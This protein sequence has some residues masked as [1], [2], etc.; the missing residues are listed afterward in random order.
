MLRPPLRFLSN[1]DIPGGVAWASASPRTP[2]AGGENDPKRVLWTPVRQRA[3][4]HA[5]WLVAVPYALL[6]LVG[7]FSGVAGFDAHAYWAAWSN[8]LYSAAPEQ[9][10]AYLYSPAFAEAI[11][12]LSLLSWPVFYAVWT[13]GTAATYAWLLAPLG[14]RWAL[15]LFVLTIPEIVV[16]NIWGLLAL[17]AVVGFRYPA[18]WTLPLLTKITPAVG[19]LWFAVRREWRAFAISLVLALGLALASVAFA[20]HLWVQWVRL[21]V[22]PDQYANPGRDAAT[23]LVHVPLFVRLPIAGCLT[24]FAARTNRRLVLPFAM[25]LA[26]PVFAVSTFQILAALPRMA[27][28]QRAEGKG[29]EAGPLVGRELEFSVS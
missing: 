14:R 4:R 10:D 28:Q 1:R 19:P 21:L 5:I 8:G 16:G 3:L 9:R 12:P 7:A 18:A 29:T 25:V 15:P 22:H 11:W 20:P 27:E 6:F 24:I 2:L 23:S 26:S 17:V 13:L